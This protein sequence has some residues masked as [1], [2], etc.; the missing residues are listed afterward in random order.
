MKNIFYTEAN[1]V[2]DTLHPE[3]TT[4]T[5][6]RR[7]LRNWQVIVIYSMIHTGVMTTIVVLATGDYRLGLLS[8]AIHATAFCLAVA[9]YNVITW[10]TSRL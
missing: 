4:P 3:F 8:L 9:S 6:R 5:H 1:P 7:G 2:D 10:A